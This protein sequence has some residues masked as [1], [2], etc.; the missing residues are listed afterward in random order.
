MGSIQVNNIGKKYK[1]YKNQ[2]ARFLE[3]ISA[4]RYIGH[5]V[6][7]VLKAISFQVQAGES[8][9]LIGINGAGKSTLLKIITGTTI[10][11]TGNVQIQGKVSALLELGMGFDGELTGRENAITGLQIL[12]YNRQQIQQLLP[13]VLHFSELAAYVDQPLRTYSSGMQVR[14]A[15]S[16]ATALRPDI[17]IIDEALSVGDAYFQHKSMARIREFRKQGTTLLFVSHD[18]G[19][20]KSLCDR[21]ILLEKGEVI[22][23]GNV[24]D[25]LD[26]Y[27]AAI[28]KREENQEIQQIEMS[29]GTM[30][31]RSGNKKA[32]IAAVTMLDAAKQDVRAFQVGD[33]VY[34]RCQ[35][36]I[37]EAMSTPTV[38]MLIRDRLGNDIFGI[39]T[40]YIENISEPS[41][42]SPKTV[43][44][45]EFHLEL[46]IGVGN[47]A[48]T[49][50]VHS[51]EEHLH[52]NYDWWDRA[53]IFKV[54]PDNQQRFI[55]LAALPAKATIAIEEK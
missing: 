23:E 55:G 4:G 13:A 35:I 14:L 29:Y 47:Y 45:V 33:S 32:M 18:P 31:T 10:P 49:F 19:A 2:K 41:H 20:V 7:W 15:F 11:S 39:N 54:I 48:L 42:L 52:D 36:E 21:A 34:I 51:G 8:V 22:K 50:A 24:Q 25:V 43:I 40:A 3:L 27:N 1:Q 17:L 53:L 9:G 38:G 12:G 16:V 6:H 30:S 44:M 5:Q 37:N 26:F 28:A 46:N